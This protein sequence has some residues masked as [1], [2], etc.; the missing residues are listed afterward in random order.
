[1]PTMHIYQS[2]QKITSKKFKNF[3]Y[4]RRVVATD[5]LFWIIDEEG[6]LSKR[7][8]DLQIWIRG[9][10]VGAEIHYVLPHWQLI[11][12]DIV[13]ERGFYNQTLYVG[14]R[15]V[16]LQYRDYRFVCTFPASKDR[17][18]TKIEDLRPSVPADDI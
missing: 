9:G 6:N 14:G 1:M 2:D 16:E 11:I 3:F 10:S 4:I 7:P 15:M 5:E 17:S 18:A 13:M 8:S 12:D